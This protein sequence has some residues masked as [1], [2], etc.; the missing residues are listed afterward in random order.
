MQ[1]SRYIVHWLLATLLGGVAVAAGPV[2]AQV[3]VTDPWV[4]GTVTGQEVTGAYM[5]LTATSPT[6]LV[7][8]ASPAAK[9]V[10]LHE[11]AMEGGVM[12]MRALPKLSLAPGKAVELKPGSYHVMLM[13][14][15]HPLKD[16][17][18]V[19]VTLIFQDASG[20]K[21]TVE[22]KALVRPLTSSAAAGA[23]SR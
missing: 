1:P 11:M 18:T 22:V 4:R 23:R 17:E 9:T 6:T 7:G 2:W 10:E 8:V 19:P 20:K 12:K 21:S 16:G 5:K 3:V 15:E 14:L 13:D